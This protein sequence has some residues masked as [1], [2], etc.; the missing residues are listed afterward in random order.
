MRGSLCHMMMHSNSSA[1]RRTGSWCRRFRTVSL[2]CTR[3]GA[4][5]VLLPCLLSGCAY[6]R[7]HHGMDAGPVPATAVPVAP[8]NEVAQVAPPGIVQT[9]GPD[10]TGIPVMPLDFPKDT[11]PK[12]PANGSVAPAGLELPG[13]TTTSTPAN[14]PT[15]PVGRGNTQQSEPTISVNAGEK[16]QELARAA[17]ARYGTIDSYIARFRRR[18]VVGGKQK[19]EETMVIKFRKEPWSVYFKW[20][21]KEGQGREVVFVPGKYGDQLHTILAAGDAPLMPAGKRFPVSPD[22]FLVR[23]NSR[24]SIREAGLGT[25]VRQFAD[26]TAAN[27]RGDLHLGTLRYLGQIRR[28]EFEQPCEAAEQI[29]APGSDPGLP[30]GGKRLWVFDP[31]TNLPNLLVTW[32]DSNREVEYYC[33]DRLEYPVNLTDDDFNPDVIWAPKPKR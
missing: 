18:E 33:Y 3:S 5:A 10:R 11:T 6:W 24:H 29:L 21:G 13:I 25:L 16:L 23:S 19:P 9:S 8:P 15:T 20:L 26:L 1:Q 17:T 4:L 31:S 27:A 30:K 7:S 14:P 32:D 28:T 22:S 12:F 2:Q